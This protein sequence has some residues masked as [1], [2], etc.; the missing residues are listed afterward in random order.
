MVLAAA[1]VA[2]FPAVP[3]QAG[4]GFTTL[5]ATLSSDADPDGSG[6]ALLEIDTKTSFGTICHEIEVQNVT[7]PVT[8]GII[9]VGKT[10]DLVGRLIIQDRGGDLA[11]C[12]AQAGIKTRDLNR[13]QRDPGSHFLHLYNEEYPCDVTGPDRACPPGALIGQLQGVS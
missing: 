8:G 9:T 10:G 3:A 2:V 12:T 11:G 7:R 13:I 4:S 6:S 1:F 5:Q